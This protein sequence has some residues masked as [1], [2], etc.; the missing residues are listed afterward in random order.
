MVL[1]PSD[2]LAS[3]AATTATSAYQCVTCTGWFDA[4]NIYALPNAD[5]YICRRCHHQQTAAAYAPPSAPQFAPPQQS[6][7]VQ[8]IIHN[9][10]ATPRWS[11][12]V[13]ALLS[14]LFPGLG[15]LYKGQVINGLV[16]MVVVIIGYVCL[17][18]PGLILH[19]CCII[20]AASGD[21]YR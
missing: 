9:Q 3:V 11:A 12:G 14:F 17:V 5:G 21:P 20:G 4:Q 16:W 7:V 18:I 1:A 2:S 15:Q 10:G 8:N 19:L 6:L 13:A